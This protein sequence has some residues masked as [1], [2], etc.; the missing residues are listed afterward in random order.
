MVLLLQALISL[1]STLETPGT[2]HQGAL[3]D[4]CREP[5]SIMI[6]KF[7]KF[8]YFVN[9]FVIAMAVFV[10]F[11]SYIREVLGNYT[12]SYCTHGGAAEGVGLVFL[13]SAPFFVLHILFCF[14]ITFQ[15]FFNVLKKSFH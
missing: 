12:Y 8:L 6:Y 7:F 13:L 3:Y 11:G 5:E 1:R 15:S 2:C 4:C 9:C 10:G 14:F